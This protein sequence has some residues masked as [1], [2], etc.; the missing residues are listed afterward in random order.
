MYIHRTLE[1]TEVKIARG[2]IVCNI[3]RLLPVD[4]VYNFIP[5]NL[6]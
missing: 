5:A 3:E 1:K 6:I 2:G 4:S